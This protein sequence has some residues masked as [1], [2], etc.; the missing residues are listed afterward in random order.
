MKIA[1]RVFI[2]IAYVISSIAVI[3]TLVV[4]A[5]FKSMVQM[6]IDSGIFIADDQSILVVEI[7]IWIY[8]VVVVIFT[9]LTFVVGVKADKHLKNGFTGDGQIVLYGILSLIFIN[10][11]AGI[12]ILLLLDVKE[13]DNTDEN[14]NK[15]LSELKDM[16]DKGLINEKEYFELKIE[17]LQKIYKKFKKH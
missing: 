3:A 2:Y 15:R 4:A 13:E 17:I 12:F 5:N 1:A 11:L 9:V 6:A 16:L 8:F 10:I 14:L 7:L